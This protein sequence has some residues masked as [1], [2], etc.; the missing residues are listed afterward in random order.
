[1][2]RAPRKAAQRQAAPKKPRTKRIPAT[3]QG[4]AGEKDAE[5]SLDSRVESTHGVALASGPRG[6]V[7]IYRHGLG[8]CIL[9]RLKRAGKED[10]KLL[11]DCGVVLGT[12]NPA[13]I[14]TR[15]AKDIVA[16]TQGAID[17]LAITHEHWDHVSGFVQ[18]KAT[19]DELKVGEVWV[20][21]TEDPADEL[22]GQLKGEFGKA[23]KMLL[24]SVQRLGAAQREDAAQLLIDAAAFG[25]AGG[26]AST[27]DALD[28]A[29]KMA[30]NGVPRY[31]K[32][33][34]APVEIDGAEARV[35]VL[36]PPRDLSAIRKINPSKSAPE[37]YALAMDGSGLLTRSLAVALGVADDAD[38]I[39]RDQYDSRPFHDR[40]SIPWDAAMADPRF[41]KYFDDGNEWRRIDGDWL[42]PAAD[43]ALAL[44]NYTNNTSL[45]LAIEIGEAGKGDVLLFA[46]DA[47]VGN[48]E[49]W[50]R[51]GWPATSGPDLLRRTIFY[52]VGHHG[53]HNATLK[54]HGLEE[55]TQLK[56]AVIPVDEAMA[57]KKRWG[58]MPLPVL[59]ETLQQRARRALRTD[60]DPGQ[61][62]AG[63]KI[64]PLYF[65][66]AI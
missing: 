37:T 24:A 58:A 13:E 62:D 4:H 17:A 6:S 21:W 27:A 19:F 28:N 23:E 22:A 66:I 11:I 44:Q 25:A 39:T 59:V 57:K 45:V 43:F 2:T 48:W 40:V 64:D 46:A 34:D 53:S 49:S 36:G 50:Q 52:K 56:T 33:T 54:Q 41:K 14:M 61:V 60:Q 15:V 3:P 63:I 35:Y 65:E 7:R 8:D 38:D 1:M 47:Q 29:K 9:L 16:E 31:L 20:G 5:D 55:M 30:K 18:A 26:G 42:G 32:P 12:P 10:F 51:C